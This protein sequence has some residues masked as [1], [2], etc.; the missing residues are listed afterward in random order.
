M[1][2]SAPAATMSFDESRGSDSEGSVWNPA[3]S[4][5]R[6]VDSFPAVGGG[7]RESSTAEAENDTEKVRTK[8]ESEDEIRALAGT[9]TSSICLRS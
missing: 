6:C 9:L 5:R 4:C 2:P 7:K 3:G 8:V 1:Y